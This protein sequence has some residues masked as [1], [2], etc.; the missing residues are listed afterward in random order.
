MK[1]ESSNFEKLIISEALKISRDKKMNLHLKEEKQKLHEC[2]CGCDSCQSR[3]EEPEYEA[4]EFEL[5]E[6][7]EFAKEAEEASML[8]EELKRMK[9]L[10]S[11]NNPLLKS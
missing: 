5:V 7:Q 11:F 3:Q 1:K 2:S 9:E 10:L 8:S 6:P 4:I